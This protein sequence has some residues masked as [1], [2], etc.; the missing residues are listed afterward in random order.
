MCQ[1]GA[2]TARYDSASSSSIG[3]NSVGELEQGESNSVDSWLEMNWS[4]GVKS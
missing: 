1:S 3:S 2:G 4:K